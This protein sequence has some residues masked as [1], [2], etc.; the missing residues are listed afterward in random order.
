MTRPNPLLQPFDLFPYASVQVEDLLPAIEKIVEENRNALALIIE[1]QADTPSWSG[2]VLAVEAL[3]KRLE[4]TFYPLVPLAFTSDEWGSAVSE[5]DAERRAYRADKHQNQ[6]LFSAYQRLDPAELSDE[7]VLVLKR[8]LRDFRLEGA[9][10]S[11]SDQQQF[12]SQEAAIVGLEGEFQEKL[13]AAT[14]H[15]SKHITDVEVLAGVPAADLADM[16]HKAQARGLSGWLLTLDEPVCKTVLQYAD[17]RD[18]RKEL[19]LAYVTRASDQATGQS[20]HDNGPVLQALLRLRHEKARLLGFVDFAEL[21]L[22]TK[23]AQSTAEVETFLSTLIA[24]ERPR[25]EREADQLRSFARQQGC[26]DLQPWDYEFYAQKLRQHEGRDPD[27]VLREYY[28]F[29][30]ALSGLIGLVEQLYGISI[31]KV[32]ADV[33]DTEVQVLQVVEAG[34]VLGHIYLDAFIRPGKPAWPWSLAMRNRHVDADGR[35][36]LPIATLFGYYEPRGMQLEHKDLCKLFHE[37]HHCLHQVLMTNSN[38]RLNSIHELGHDLSEF[39]GKL[40]EQWCWSAQSLQS[41]STHRT[42][43]ERASLAQVQRWLEART[44]QRGLEKA[45]D[46]KKA[47]LDFELHRGYRNHRGIEQVVADVYARTQILPLVSNDRFA[48]GFDYMVTGYEAGFYCYL[49]AEEH[50]T[51]VFA[52]FKD[53]GIFDSR[54]GRAMRDELLAPGTSRSMS[55]SIQAFLDRAQSIVSAD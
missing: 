43:G 40:L 48:N 53:Q 20:Q 47:L 49:W 37:F 17:S 51:D 8:I 9:N 46:L 23:A 34:D 16:Q 12:A 15:L 13:R 5:C 4:D 45:D 39:A 11:L 41:V 32:E 55:A 28:S 52:R 3:D 31:E 19:Y 6:E 25:L 26:D 24:R 50:A 38:R 18:L 7:Q 33:W 22:Q 10:I 1:R 36:S 54:L 44:T 21:S 35:V 30:T 2:L 14:D 29:E 27:Q 42:S